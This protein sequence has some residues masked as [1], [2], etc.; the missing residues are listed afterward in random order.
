[1]K[2]FEAGQ[3]VNVALLLAVG[4]DAGE[5]TDAHM[6]FVAASDLGFGSGGGY[7]TA[8]AADD[9]AAMLN[10]LPGRSEPLLR[11]DDPARVD[12]TWLGC[13]QEDLLSSSAGLSSDS[14]VKMVRG[15]GRLVRCGPQYCRLLEHWTGASTDAAGCC[16][17]A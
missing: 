17:L 4:L 16:C 6:G 12:W 7:E 8:A 5:S 11:L 13:A 2:R 10:L 14:R 1:M 9:E 15:E 3:T